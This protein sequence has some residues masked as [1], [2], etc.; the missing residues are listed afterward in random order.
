MNI[1]AHVHMYV[2]NHNAGAECMLHDILT[3]MVKR[4]HEA[5]V[6]CGSPSVESVDGVKLYDI[7]TDELFKLYAW[8]DVVITH[9]DKTQQAITLAKKAKKPI[10]HIIHNDKQAIVHNLTERNASLLVANSEWI[11]KT[12][13]SKAPKIIVYPPIDV[14]KYRVETQRKTITLINL[15]IAK[16][17]DVFYELARRN[18]EKNFLGVVGGYGQQLIKEMPNVTIL[19]HTPDIQSVYA[20]S[21]IVLMPSTYE[22]WGRVAMEAGASGIPVIARPTPGLKESLGDAGLFAQTV[23]EFENIIHQLDDKIAYQEACDRIK[24]RV[25]DL[26]SVNQQQL[27]TLYGSMLKMGQ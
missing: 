16:G 22:S 3:Y 5:R 26:E 15:T 18:P 19:P 12:L 7:E 27:N 23:D 10:I 21:R 8:A 4:G 1:L 6:I 11:A 13:R 20:Q 14:S 2:P 24:A 9:L 25:L 17:A